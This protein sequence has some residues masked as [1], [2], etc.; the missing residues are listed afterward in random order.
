MKF[1]PKLFWI[2][3]VCL[4]LGAIKEGH[5]QTYGNWPYNYYSNSYNYGSSPYYPRAYS[6]RTTFNEQN[7]VI[8]GDLIRINCGRG[9]R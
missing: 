6:S 4:L 5:C 1:S 2:V 9:R 3:F 8:C 7:G